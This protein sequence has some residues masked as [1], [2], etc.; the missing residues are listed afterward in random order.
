MVEICQSMPLIVMRTH[1]KG[2]PPKNP[3]RDHV[4]IHDPAHA[5]DLHPTAQGHPPPAQDLGRGQTQRGQAIKEVAQG[6]G[7]GN[8]VKG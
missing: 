8:L 4:H 1:R 3:D 6:L 7:Q 5:P 2:E